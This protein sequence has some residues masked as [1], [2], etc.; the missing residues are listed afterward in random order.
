ML[1]RM[2]VR[3]VH[4]HEVTYEHR[5][6]TSRSDIYHRQLDGYVNFV[7]TWTRQSIIEDD[8]Y[9]VCQLY[10]LVLR[11]EMKMLKIDKPEF[12]SL[13]NE[14]YYA[15]FSVLFISIFCRKKMQTRRDDY[16]PSLP[17]TCKLM[18]L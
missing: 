7:I 14:V 6:D 17:S 10:S 15:L 18:L 8:G 5:S 1:K 4:L 2:A 9:G 13:S 16:H 11:Q 3:K 12:G